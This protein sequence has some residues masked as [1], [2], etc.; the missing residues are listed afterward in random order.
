MK[1]VISSRFDGVEPKLSRNNV[2]FA[3]GVMRWQVMLDAASEQYI[4]ASAEE[5][6]TL[7]Q[8]FWELADEANV[9]HEMNSNT[10]R[11]ARR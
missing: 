7:A 11:E 5:L 10:H 6:R 2:R 8:R 3:D 1:F 9:S 4:Y